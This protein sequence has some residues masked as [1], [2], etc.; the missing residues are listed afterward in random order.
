[1]FKVTEER[2]FTRT[3][4]VMVPSDG[5][6]TKETC[7]ATYRVVDIDELDNTHTLDGQQTLLQ[8]VVVELGDL[9]GDDGKD[10]PYSDK[11]RDQLIRIPFMRAALLRTY[12]EAVS[13]ARVGN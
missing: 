7:T 3:V 11:L 10:V 9:V 1:M 6:H 5:G 8:R 12:M 4:D 2:T 13:G